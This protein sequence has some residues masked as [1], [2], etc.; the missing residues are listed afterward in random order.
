ML[1]ALTVLALGAI[2]VVVGRALTK[3]DEQVTNASASPSQLQAGLAPTP[4]GNPPVPAS[5]AVPQALLSAAAPASGSPV[6]AHEAEDAKSSRAPI[7]HSAT[8]SAAVKGG[9]T[10][11]AATVSSA[12]PVAS[13]KQTVIGNPPTHRDYDKSVGF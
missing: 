5:G 7:K 4:Q 2:G 12:M 9:K 10:T 11:G 13:A 8:A 3:H 1:I 6:A